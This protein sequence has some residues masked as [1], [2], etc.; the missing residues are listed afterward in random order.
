AQLAADVGITD[1]RAGLLPADKVTQVHQLQQAGEQVLLVGDGVNDA[2][3]MA[4]ANLGVA[5]GRHGSDLALETSDA[6]IVHDELATLPKVIDV[7]GQAHRVV[8]GNLVFASIVIAT[9]VVIDLVWILP[10][11]LGVAGHE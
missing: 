5:M 10:L 2:P 4:A 11:P 6:V 1:V 8:K 9:L 7:S 3:A